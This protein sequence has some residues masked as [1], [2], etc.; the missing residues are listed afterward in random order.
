MNICTHT[1]KILKYIYLHA[2]HH[3]PINTSQGFQ[4]Q[5]FNV[6][7]KQGK[8]E[9]IFLDLKFRTLHLYYNLP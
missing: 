1:E 9:P 8:L 7:S 4:I 2:T 6:P 3:Q 5:R